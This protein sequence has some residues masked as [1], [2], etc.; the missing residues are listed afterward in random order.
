METTTTMMT[1]KTGK[2]VAGCWA[3]CLEDCN[4]KLSR[5]HQVSQCFW[6]E[7]PNIMMQGLPWCPEPKNVGIGSLTAKIL[8]E[9]HNSLLGR[10]V[11]PEAGT[12]AETIREAMRLLEVR[13]KMRLRSYTPVDFTINGLMLERWFLKTMFNFSN[14]QTVPMATTAHKG[15]FSTQELVE[16]VFGLRSFR[17]RAGLYFAAEIVQGMMAV[18]RRLRLSFYNDGDGIISGLFSF[19]GFKFYLNLLPSNIKVFNEYNLLYHGQGIVLMV[20]DK[21]NRPVPSHRINFTW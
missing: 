8:C 20:P 3:E 5:E 21:K 16:I 4:G 7:D 2:R 13:K 11:D 6:G 14:T 12:A 18:E 10:E 9:R 19:C 17:H 15:G 1:T